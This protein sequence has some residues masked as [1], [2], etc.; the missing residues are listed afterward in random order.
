MKMVTLEDFRAG[1]GL[2]Q[3]LAE[4]KGEMEALK[5]ENKLLREDRDQW[6]AQAQ[7]LANPARVVLP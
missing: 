3:Q 2:V 1:M 7:S 6:R 4:W 5:A